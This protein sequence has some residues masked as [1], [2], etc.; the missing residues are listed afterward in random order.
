MASR[1]RGETDTDKPRK[2]ANA[3]WVR[4]GCWPATERWPQGSHLSSKE[5]AGLV[6]RQLAAGLPQASHNR[7]AYVVVREEG[8]RDEGCIN[9]A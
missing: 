2:P 1:G 8:I 9:R 3:L 7:A 4:A 5:H 6:G